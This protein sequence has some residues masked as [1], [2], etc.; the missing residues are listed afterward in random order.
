MAWNDDDEWGTPSRIN[1]TT[2]DQYSLSR[3]IEDNIVKELSKNKLGFRVSRYTLENKQGKEIAQ[4]IILKSGSRV[5]CPDVVV[6]HPS[7]SYDV[8]M[9]VEIKNHQSVFDGKYVRTEC[10]KFEDYKNLQY[11]EEVESRMIFYVES[12][13]LKLWQTI[14]NLDW[15]KEKRKN[16]E[17]KKGLF[18]DFYYWPIS[19]FNEFTSADE[20]FRDVQI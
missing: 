1:R 15:H 5:R 6:I 19:A 7:S 16:V 2:Q 18:V 12:N 20:F 9:R 14:D 17:I 11:S 10:V 3:R 8:S 13:G 4:T